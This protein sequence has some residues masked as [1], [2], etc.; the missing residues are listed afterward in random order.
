MSVSLN[1]ARFSE[2]DRLIR[3]KTTL[4]D[5]ELLLDKIS[6]TEALSTP[7]EF[8]V[9]MMSTNPTIDLKGLLRKPA[10][11]IISMPDGL[12]RPI[13]AIFSSLK[14]GGEHS[15]DLFIYE[16]TLVPWLWFLSL[17]ADCR[18]FQNLS[19]QEIV[20]QILN[21]AGISDYVFH[22]S[23]KYPK[24]E[25]CVQYRESGLNFISRLLEEEGIFY[26][27]EHEATKHTIVFRDSS[28]AVDPCPE[29]PVVSYSFSQTG[30][31]NDRDGVK[32]V[33]RTE[34]V[35]T[36]KVALT[37]YFPE[38][39]IFNLMVNLEG[40]GAGNEEVYDYPGEYVEREEGERYA[41]IRLEERE[42]HQFV[43][44]GTSRCRA[45]R[46]GY[47]FTLED[48]YRDD[49]NLEYVLTEVTHEATDTS[50]RSSGEAAHSYANTFRAI[51]KTVHFRPSRRTGKPLIKGSQTALVVGV[52]GQEIMVD[53]YGRVKVQFY[54]DR[55]GQKDEKSSCWV[56]VSQIWAGKNWG[57]MTIPRIGQEVIV[58]FLEGDPDY[59][60]ITGRVYNADQMPP[61]T[62]PDNQTQSGIKSR[63]SQNGT[64]DNFNQIRF[65]DLK[66]SEMVSVQAEKDMETLVKN[67]DTQTIKN[68]RQ[69]DV[70]GTHTETIVKDTTIKITEGNHSLTVSEGNQSTTVSMGN[71]SITISMGNQST[72]IEL[73]RSE[74]EA[75][76]SIELKVGANSIK[77]DQM[78]VTIK[79][80]MVQIKGDT[81]T[82]VQGQAMLML[83]GGITMI[84]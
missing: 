38:K 7:F 3:I 46:A 47:R 53:K 61:Y 68:N 57:W 67:D 70:T 60:I 15:E 50:Y 79:G 29:L 41:R 34:Q 18:I 84:N 27:F 73:G 42:A 11:V 39:P 36:K 9:L 58:D 49:T 16:G 1:E 24:R 77:I 30:W 71:Q 59:P 8:R 44:E 75:M 2:K 78:G 33:E 54:W 82:S 45:F 66:D 35:H 21:D 52:S 81:I 20:T 62:L 32:T 76:Q 56:R 55:V 4:E 74:T 40:N 31:K 13:H 37:A 23:G 22:L 83:K 17:D 69:I 26:Y 25:Y 51:P 64:A 80:L 63:S 14:Q 65:E 5:S 12:E 48:H 72:K 19:V 6:G 10:T 28:A 43:V